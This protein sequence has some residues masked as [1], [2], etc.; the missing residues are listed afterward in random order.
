MDDLIPFLIFVG[1]AL[2]N[3]VKTAIERGGAKKAPR[4]APRKA[5]PPPQ[6]TP[7]T[8]EEFF[9]DIAEQFGVVEEEE[10]EDF[11]EPQTPVRVEQELPT[12]EPIPT[13]IVPLPIKEASSTKLA[14]MHKKAIGTAMKSMPNTLL[15]FDA[16][17]LPSIPLL[18]SAQKGTLD[19]P[20]QN[21]K[22][23]KNAIIANIIF[24]PP[25]VFSTEDN[26]TPLT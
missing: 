18:S 19:F 4:P 5:T 14:V 12:Y 24:S 1:V 13:P 25:R 16:M 11:F 23:F 10:E 26:H 9:E 20:L 2:I 6:Q 15:S 3:L 8:L 17:K 21:R 7:T 22:T